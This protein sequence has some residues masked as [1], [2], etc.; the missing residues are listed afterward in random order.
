MKCK[1]AEKL[2]SALF[3]GE[4]SAEEED[5]V[6]A[7]LAE[8]EADRRRYR[9]F[10]QAIELVRALPR[11]EAPAS[12]TADVMRRVR[13]RGPAAAREYPLERV[14]APRIF[15]FPV[16]TWQ[17]VLAA[18]ATLALGI[19][20]GVLLMRALDGSQAE[21]GLSAA[22]RSDRTIESVG[23]VDAATAGVDSGSAPLPIWE[24]FER[25][26]VQQV[27]SGNERATIIF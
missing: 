9:A 12:F 15:R 8:C 5:A 22:E 1:D 23:S 6:R 2:F 13:A 7:H 25:T 11:E 19:S 10:E 14:R 24:Q 17:P 3:D 27:T 20:S 21:S 16:M 18:A 4:L 26:P